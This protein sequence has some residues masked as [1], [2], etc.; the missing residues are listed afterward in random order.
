MI[1]LGVLPA[2]L[3]MAACGPV[4]LAQAERQCLARAYDASGP[5]GSVGVGV[6][7]DGKAKAKV[8]LGISS[9][10]LMGRDPSAVYDQCVFQK[11]GQ[12]PSQPLYART[13]WKG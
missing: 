9:D 8:S 13:D 6:G 7:G 5:H 3:A 11:S 12:M 1:R 4:T 2:L 10:Y